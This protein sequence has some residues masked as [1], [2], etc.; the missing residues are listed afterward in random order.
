MALKKVQDQ[1]TALLQNIQEVEESLKK[2]KS[3]CNIF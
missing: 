3:K 2:K 1:E